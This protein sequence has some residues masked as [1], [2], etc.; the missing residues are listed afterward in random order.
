MTAT[1]N[2][3]LLFEVM[4]MLAEL[5]EGETEHF[6]FWPVTPEGVRI[7]VTCSDVFYWGCADAEIV[8]RENFPQLRQA[9]LDEIEASPDDVALHPGWLFVARLRNLRPQGA[10]YKALEY[11]EVPLF[12]AAGPPREINFSNPKSQTDEYLWPTSSAYQDFMAKRGDEIEP[13][14]RV[15]GADSA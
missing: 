14:P 1:D 3:D 12:D 7:S 13:Q 8:T 6:M 15:A 4:C 2:R 10:I 5:D 11:W 9:Y